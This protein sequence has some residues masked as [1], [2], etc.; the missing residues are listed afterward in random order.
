MRRS[1]RRYTSSEKSTNIETV[2][3]IDYS[4]LIHR[5]INTA[6]KDDKY[7]SD[8]YALWKSYV[9]VGKSAHDG[10][11][12]MIQKHKPDRVIIAL[13]EK[14]TWRKEMF[15]DYKAHRGAIRK[16]SK[17]DYEEFFK[18]SDKF[19]DEMAKVFKNIIFWG[20]EKCEADDLIAVIAKDIH[21]DAKVIIAS[22]DKDFFQLQVNP[23]VSQYCPLKR[24]FRVCPNPELDLRIKLLCGDRKDNVPGVKFRTGPK[25]AEKILKEGLD[26][27]LDSEE[28]LR[29]KYILNRKLIDFNYIPED[30]HQ[31]IL[32]DYAKIEVGDVDQ[33]SF[34]NF[35]IRNKLARVAA[36]F[37]IYSKYT[38]KLI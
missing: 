28:G 24:E 21:K 23:N 33:A 7:C 26:D 27:F 4:N 14:L 20:V 13:D 15:D 25:T 38:E 8:N 2:L 29:D 17:V 32:D 30:I 9:M 35:F 31:N 22:S 3:V 19:L 11:F 18:I 16:K 12:G 10:I 34:F 1:R 6:V 36:E 5:T 37:G